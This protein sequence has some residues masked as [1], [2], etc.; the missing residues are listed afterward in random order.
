MSWS[1]LIAAA[2]AYPGAREQMGLYPEELS[3]SQNTLAGFSRG[4]ITASVRRENWATSR[5]YVIC[6]F[7]F[8]S[9]VNVDIDSEES[10]AYE[11]DGKDSRLSGLYYRS[12]EKR[13]NKV[14][15]VQINFYYTII[16]YKR[17]NF[18]RRPSQCCGAWK[19][20]PTTLIWFLLSSREIMISPV[21][22]TDMGINA[23]FL[24]MK[25]R[26]KYC[27]GPACRGWPGLWHRRK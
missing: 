14:G 6:N 24:V 12:S 9:T 18:S 26:L 13:G 3:S 23:C 16:T 25:A 11:S 7:C 2:V 22:G 17:D 21:C 1:I 19:T 15:G 27:H 20:V 5:F 8:L 10:S 4:C